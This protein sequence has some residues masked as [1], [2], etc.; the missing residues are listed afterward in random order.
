MQARR[1]P[2]HLALTL[3]YLALLAYIAVTDLRAFR[4]PDHATLPLA[5]GGLAWVF[6]YAPSPWLNLAA[7]IVAGS[8]FL[9]L[10][11]G[12]Q[13]LRGA[14][15][16]GLGDAKLVAAG[17]LWVGTGIALAIALGAGTALA[18][19]ALHAWHGRHAPGDPIPFGPYMAAG[20]G[21]VFL[22]G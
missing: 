20:M 9:A 12:F 17:A 15:G 18:V 8:V 14:E 22:L 5:I 3:L 6:L 13:R 16:L 2:L 1:P 21:A 4:I 10:A 11:A 7:A 19:T